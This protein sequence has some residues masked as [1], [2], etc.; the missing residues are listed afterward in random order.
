MKLFSEVSIGETFVVAGGFVLKKISNTMAVFPEALN[1]GEIPH[2][3][4]TQTYTEA[5]FE[6]LLLSERERPHVEFHDLHDGQVFIA[7][8]V[9]YIKVNESSE[10]NAVYSK[11]PQSGIKFKPTDWAELKIDI[12]E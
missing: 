8:G 3:G 2:D 9:E 1:V 4:V 7:H 5:E 12:D 11:K 10:Y 6:E